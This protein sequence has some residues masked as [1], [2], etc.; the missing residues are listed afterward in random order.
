[1]L[2]D[3][4]RA[5]GPESEAEA[6]GKRRDASG[7]SSTR[8][9]SGNSVHGGGGDGDGDRD[10]DGAVGVAVARA[11]SKVLAKSQQLYDEHAAIEQRREQRRKVNKIWSSR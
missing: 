4:A 2:L 10:G 9:T 7:G 5:G 8:M 1:M 3:F 6:G 11:P